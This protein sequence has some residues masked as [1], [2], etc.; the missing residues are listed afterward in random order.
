MPVSPYLYVLQTMYSA[1]HYHTVMVAQV[2]FVSDE[3]DASRYV[4]LE[5]TNALL[6]VSSI[7]IV[8]LAGICFHTVLNL[9]T[10]HKQNKSS[11]N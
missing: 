2:G 8:Q 1:Q 4:G 11:A 10:E 7:F 9:H 6:L 3:P 5:N